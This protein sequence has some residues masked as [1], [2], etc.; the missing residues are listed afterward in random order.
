MGQHWVKDGK[1]VQITNP[2]DPNY[3]DPSQG[4]CIWKVGLTYH[5]AKTVLTILVWV[6]LISSARGM[7]NIRLM[8][9]VQTMI[10]N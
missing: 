5:L 2:N 1:T 3:A 10:T 6:M 4:V 7:L 8:G 9:M